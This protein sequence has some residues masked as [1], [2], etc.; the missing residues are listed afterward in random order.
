MS[1]ISPCKGCPDRHPACHGSCEK[2]KEWLDAYHAE[3]KHF[4]DNKHRF[5]IPWTA[6]REKTARRYLRFGESG[7]KQGGSQ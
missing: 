4:Q 6:S 1:G 3:Q 2:Y 5:N 7:F